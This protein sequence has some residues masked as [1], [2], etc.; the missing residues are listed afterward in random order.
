[1]VFNVNSRFLLK[2]NDSWIWR[3]LL[4]CDGVLYAAWLFGFF[5]SVIGI[6]LVLGYWHLCIKDKTRPEQIK[7]GNRSFS[8]TANVSYYNCLPLFAK[9]CFERSGTLLAPSSVAHKTKASGPDNQSN[10]RRFRYGNRRKVDTRIRQSPDPASKSADDK[11][12]IN[13]V[14]LDVRNVGIGKVC[15]IEHHPGMGC[16][17]SE[18]EEETSCG[19]H[20]N[21]T[22]TLTGNGHEPDLRETSLGIAEEAATRSE[23]S[24]EVRPRRS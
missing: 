3:L 10:S 6:A 17:I 21:G 9:R 20:N 15:S 7:T 18:V 23:I 8:N 14:V 11:N 4:V 5:F 12:I 16:I 13:Q 24:C 22:K 2:L 1:M 19:A